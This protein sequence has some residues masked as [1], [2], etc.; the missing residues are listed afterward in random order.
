MYS[1]ITLRDR[2][3]RFVLYIWK[4]FHFLLSRFRSKLNLKASLI[5]AFATFLLLSYMKMGYSAFYILA[6][7]RVYSPDGPYVW[8]VYVDP[9]LKY[10]GPSHI[11]YALPTLLFS[12]ILLIFPILLLFLYPCQC[13]Q[14]CLNHFH[15]RLLVLH[16]FVDAF[17]GCY[18]DGTNGTRDCLYFTALILIICLHYPFLC[19]VSK[20][21]VLPNLATFWVLSLFITLFFYLSAL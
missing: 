21:I 20:E 17:Q 1:F 16:A 12:F 18:K 14:R 3:C 6:P 2:G 8:A 19:F 7:S 10:F 4:P 9:S 5:D 15:L 13:F 11:G